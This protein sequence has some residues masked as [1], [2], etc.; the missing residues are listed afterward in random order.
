MLY[1]FNQQK[2]VDEHENITNKLKIE[3]KEIIDMFHFHL[4]NYESLKNDYRNPSGL[5][6]N[7][8]IDMIFIVLNKNNSI[9]FNVKFMTTTWSQFL[10]YIDIND[11]DIYESNIEKA[12]TL[13]AEFSHK[14]AI[15]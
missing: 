12:S 7:Q 1:L 6:T 9:R 13:G 11:K 2:Y 8:V 15:L 14:S 10:Y 4:P 5:I 3:N